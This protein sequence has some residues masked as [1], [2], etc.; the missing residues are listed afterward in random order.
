MDDSSMAPCCLRFAPRLSLVPGTRERLVRIEAVTQPSL[1]RPH[2][3]T[4]QPSIAM[5]I[6]AFVCSID[7]GCF[8]D[9]EA[10]PARVLCRATGHEADLRL[11]DWEI[12]F[13]TL[14]SGA[15]RTLVW[16]AKSSECL[17]SG[18]IA[19]S[20]LE[21]AVA[22]RPRIARAQL[23]P[24]PPPEPPFQVRN[25]VACEQEEVRV[26]VTFGAPIRDD[27]LHA[28][29]K[30]FEMWGIVLAFGGF[31]G[32]GL[33]FSTGILCGVGQPQPDQVT[34]LFEVFNGGADAWNA[35]LRGLCCLHATAPIASV[36][37][38]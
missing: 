34:A 22:D 2:S 20:I 7:R 38:F 37:I 14:P 19:L 16:M 27:A 11:Q 13:P 5:V 28:A 18:L 32:A 8:A 36:Q 1:I 33:P 26:L 29:R 25:A 3:L 24:L 31:A 23:E 6:S 10:A 4:L 12:A 9:R 15:F 21:I 30:L 17:G 35:L